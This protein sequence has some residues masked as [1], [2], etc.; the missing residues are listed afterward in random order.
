MLAGRSRVPPAAIGLMLAALA[1]PRIQP[2]QHQDSIHHSLALYA[3]ELPVS[4]LG[5]GPHSTTSTVSML[6][7]A[8]FGHLT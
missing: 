2:E 6:I 3:P 1:L 4:A 7:I 5:T 8:D